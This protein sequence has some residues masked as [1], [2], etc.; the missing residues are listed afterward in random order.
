MSF[1]LTQNPFHNIAAGFRYLCMEKMD[2]PLTDV[3]PLLVTSASAKKGWSAGRSIDLG[4]IATTLISHLE[5]FHAM[6]LLFVDVKADNF[7]HETFKCHA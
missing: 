4:P 3:V 7:M 6:R 2:G 5:A 1:L